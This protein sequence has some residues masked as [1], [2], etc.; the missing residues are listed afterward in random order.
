MPSV[1]KRRSLF[2]TEIDPDSIQIEL[3]GDDKQCGT[4]VLS[5]EDLRMLVSKTNNSIF[6]LSISIES[7]FRIYP[8]YTVQQRHHWLLLMIVQL[9]YKNLPHLKNDL[10]LMKNPVKFINYG[11]HVHHK[12][13]Q[14]IMKNANQLLNYHYICFGIIKLK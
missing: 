13:L 8:I 2:E 1:L 9:T 10:T 14:F 5:P 11:F 6:S 12:H 4:L 7:N 3:F